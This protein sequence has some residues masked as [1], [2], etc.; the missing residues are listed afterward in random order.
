[1]KQKLAD[2]LPPNEF[3]L[4]DC[5]ED[6]VLI[7]WKLAMPVGPS[8]CK[9]V[10]SIDGVTDII[11]L[12]P[13]LPTRASVKCDVPYQNAEQLLTYARAHQM[14]AW[15]YAVLY[16]SARGGVNEQEVL[17]K[18]GYIFSV[19]EQAVDSGLAGTSYENRIL[20]PQAYKMDEKESQ[21]V[22]AIP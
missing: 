2:M 8:V 11:C 12:E 20:G 16:E 15:Q 1:M 13:I 19:M 6:R 10:E 5:K 7:N 21:G 22:C 18:M 14:H 17:D 4:E 9:A 3:C